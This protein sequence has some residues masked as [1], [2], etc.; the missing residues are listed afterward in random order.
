MARTCT[1]CAHPARADIDAALAV[2]TPLDRVVAQ[3]A[4]ASRSALHRHRTSHAGRP[5]TFHLPSAASVSSGSVD[6]SAVL[7]SLFAR[8][9]SQGRTLQ[10]YAQLVVDGL[11]HTYAAAVAVGD[12]SLAVRALRE[13]R[14]ILQFH[15]LV[16]LEKL[17]QAPGWAEP[18]VARDPA[19]AMMQLALAPVFQ[20]D[21]P[22]DDALAELETRWPGFAADWRASGERGG[23]ECTD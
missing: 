9:S 4:L 19:H 10:D 20:A 8:A 22:E 21:S 18:P 14:A 1:I 11:A 3:F 23:S 15:A 16:P 2:G 5:V 7:E 12:H 6:V 13:L 17:K